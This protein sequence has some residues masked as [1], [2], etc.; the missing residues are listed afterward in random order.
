MYL[1]GILGAKHNVDRTIQ[2]KYSLA[3]RESEKKN[4]QEVISS[5]QKEWKTNEQ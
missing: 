5:S 4:H 1:F 3:C 2:K